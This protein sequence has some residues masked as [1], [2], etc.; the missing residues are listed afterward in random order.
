M[1]RSDSFRVRSV[2]VTPAGSSPPSAASTSFDLVDEPWIRCLMPDREVRS[3]GLRDTL[4]NAARIHEITDASPLVTV[5]LHRLL[6]ALLHRVFGPASADEWAK[7]WR[8]GEFPQSALEAYFEKWRHRFDLFSP[9]YPF[10][11]TPTVRGGDTVPIATIVHELASS[12]NKATLFDHTQS[13]ELTPA[14]ATHGLLAFQSFAVGGW[15]SFLRGEPV[16]LAKSAQACSLTR[17]AVALVKGDNLF[18]TLLLNLV[19]YD[20]ANEEPWKAAPSDRPAWERDDPTTY[21]DRWPLGYLDWLTWQSRR[22]LLIPEKSPDGRTVVRECVRMKGYQLPDGWFRHGHETMLAYRQRPRA[23]ENEDPWPPLEFQE[24]R[25]LWRDSQALFQSADD[26]RRPMTLSWLHDLIAKGI[27]EQSCTQPLEILGM[28]TNKA[29]VMFWRHE[30]LPL[31]LAML[32]DGELV[33]Q[34]GQALKLAE[35]VGAK[36]DAAVKLLAW[37]VLGPKV[38]L[39][40]GR[41]DRLEDA[42]KQAEKQSDA[43]RNKKESVG[44]LAKSLGS[45]LAYWP[46]LEPSFRKLLVELPND[47]TITDGVAYYGG[48]ILPEWRTTLWRAAFA[49][50]EVAISGLGS[51]RRS[52]R[53]VAISE[54]LL[55]LELG[56]VLKSRSEASPVAKGEGDLAGSEPTPDEKEL[57][58]EELDELADIAADEDAEDVEDNADE[59]G[60]EES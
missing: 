52:A 45:A 56:R 34:L 41:A 30:R 11:Q 21:D 54:H 2:C 12:A 28:T 44:S 6:L 8:D 60:A 29:N 46:R 35:G 22:M 23:K 31:A 38:K 36:L 59:E 4:E 7:L 40:T 55:R 47:V 5:A 20:P 18:Q 14:Q 32:D 39:A 10:Y 53:A 37:Q 50:F 51:P 57:A 25:A 58:E 33:S 3:L 26:H 24:D 27:V 1:P 43:S 48:R 16:A 13:A 42:L 9:D 15:G 49:A 19:R 17:T